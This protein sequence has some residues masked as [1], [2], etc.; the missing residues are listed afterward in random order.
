MPDNLRLQ[1]AETARRRAASE[2]EAK[3]LNEDEQEL[4][5]QA[6]REH[7]HPTEIVEL[8]GRS[9]AHVRKLR[10]KDVPPLREG[11]GYAAIKKRR[12]DSA[13]QPE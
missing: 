11:G 10:P 6:W 9:L 13:P 8:T 12:N 1:L 7:I 2:A 3:A 4:I 5:R